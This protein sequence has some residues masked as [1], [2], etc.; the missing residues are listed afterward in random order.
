MGF[1]SSNKK[2][3]GVTSAGATK[4]KALDRTDGDDSF[5]CRFST[6]HTH[7]SQATSHASLRDYEKVADEIPSPPPLRRRN[8]LPLFMR[9]AVESSSTIHNKT[10]AAPNERI[11][12]EGTPTK[13]RRKKSNGD[14]T[15]LS[16]SAAAYAQSIVKRDM[17]AASSHSVASLITGQRVYKSMADASYV[18]SESTISPSIHSDITSR[19]L[20]LDNDLIESEPESSPLVFFPALCLSALEDRQEASLDDSKSWATL[21]VPSTQRMV[22]ENCIRCLRL[23]YCEDTTS[24]CRTSTGPADMDSVNRHLIKNTS[25]MV[26]RGSSKAE[27]LAREFLQAGNYD[28]AIVFAK[29]LLKAEQAKAKHSVAVS[30]QA[31]QL[32]LLCLAA[33][34]NREATHY[35]DEAMQ[36]LPTVSKP[37]RLHSVA[38]VNILLDHGLVQ[39]GTN[40]VGQAVKSWREAIH[41]AIAVKG[42]EDTTVAVLLNDIGVLHMETGDLKSSLRSLEESLQLQRTILGSGS[43]TGKVGSVDDA[44]YRLATTMGNLAVAYERNDRADRAVSFL[45]E[46]LVLYTSI[47]ADTGEVEGIVQ[48]N[49]ERLF[50]EQEKRHSVDETALN[51]SAEYE[52]DGCGCRLLDNTRSNYS[53]ALNSFETAD[54]Y[55]ED[56]SDDEINRDGGF[57]VDSGRSKGLFGN[58]DGLPTPSR[59][60]AANLHFEKSDNHDFL[61]LGALSPEYTA[62]QRVRETVLTWFG[63]RVDDDPMITFDVHLEII[64]DD[65]IPTSPHSGPSVPNK[66]GSFNESTSVDFGGED[67]LNADLHLYEI[68]KQAMTHLDRKEIEN[69]LKL[70]RNALQS[71][72]NKYGNEHHLVGSALHNI[73]M[74]LF[75]AKRYSDA[76]ATFQDAV[77]VRAKALG[78][79]HPDVQSSLV[80]IALIHLAL[81]DLH[82]ARCT[83]WEIRD[84]AEQVLGYGHPQLAKM[85]NNVGA[86][87]YEFG[88]LANALR[89]FEVAYKYQRRLLED[90][91][92]DESDA[93]H[94]IV[95]LAMANTLS[96]M[97]FVYYKSG[98]ASEALEAYERAY[99]L[100]RDHLPHGHHRVVEVR[101]N[102]DFVAASLYS[103]SSEQLVQNDESYDS[104]IAMQK[105]G[106]LRSKNGCASNLWI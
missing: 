104:G 12:Q 25:S 19:G 37:T 52:D 48:K 24:S 77:F 90:L 46:A 49:L 11:F 40:K 73:G 5:S 36:C 89:S 6:D 97:A 81:G 66:Q 39:F 91:F 56:E 64:G 9:Q 14:T 60:V 67:V 68:H 96:N 102:I 79:D 85:N 86:I 93:N 2:R 75:F 44:I 71:H 72:R 88:D 34:R 103:S 8:C 43:E 33:G 13:G 4:K 63:K 101:G 20:D 32:A 23:H 7:S 70:F 94:E 62:E 106:W 59:R 21:F 28:S 35:S 30:T 47:L 17:P 26:L 105:E 78:P 3:K 50:D 42:Y 53:V 22:R 82:Q 41:M 87:E 10:S 38:A 58:S 57:S 29:I 55:L 31:G 54:E 16:L 15:P 83:F 27:R 99:N 92:A 84:K 80:K 76:L 98:Q 65:G 45:D 51:S 74:V 100:L 18:T 1:F 95:S 61:L 69:A